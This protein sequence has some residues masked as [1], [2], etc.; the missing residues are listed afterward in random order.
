MKKQKVIDRVLDYLWNQEFYE[1]L[2]KEIEE[3]IHR[4]QLKKMR[5]KNQNSEYRFS[6]R[7][8]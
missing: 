7:H 3:D 1:V 6:N 5:K 2:F 8:P 4:Y